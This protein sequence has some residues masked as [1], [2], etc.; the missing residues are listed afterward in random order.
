VARLTPPEDDQQQGDKPP[1]PP[2]LQ[3]IDKWLHNPAILFTLLSAF[4]ALLAALVLI[5]GLAG[6]GLWALLAATAL[7]TTKKLRNRTNITATNATLEPGAPTHNKPDDTQPD[8][9]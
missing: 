2:W 8:G 9:Q 4:L 5:A 3:L 1:L 7:P 6:A